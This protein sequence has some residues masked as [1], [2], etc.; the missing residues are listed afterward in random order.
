M[1]I[2]VESYGMCGPYCQK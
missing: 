2:V 1:K